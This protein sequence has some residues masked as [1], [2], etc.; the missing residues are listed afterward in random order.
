MMGQTENQQESWKIQFT[1]QKQI[2][3]NLKLHIGILDS[4]I[5]EQKQMIEDIEKQK[6][7]NQS[8][9]QF[10]DS[11]IDELANEVQLYQKTIQMVMQ[12]MGEQQRNVIKNYIASNKQMMKLN[13]KTISGGNQKEIEVDRYSSNRQKEIDLNR[14]NSNRQ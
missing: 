4:Q 3:K 9:E 10:K 1:K 8:G 13:R 5:R 2:N 11:R 12:N 6:K 7:R 14:F